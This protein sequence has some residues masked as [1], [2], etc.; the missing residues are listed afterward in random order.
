MSSLPYTVEI[1]VPVYNEESVLEANIRTLRTYLDRRFP[2]RTLIT[3]ADNAS[4]DRTWEIAAR[5][6][7]A[8]DGVRSIHLAEK[9][10]GRALKAVWQS[11]T[12]QVVA[13]MDVDLSTGL[14]AMLPLVAPL[15]SGH[16]DVAIGSRLASGARVIRGPKREAISRIYNL[17]IRAGTGNS[18]TDAQCGFK[19]VRAATAR[20]LLPLVKDNGWFFDTELLMLAEHNGLRIHEVPVDW[21][22]DP[23][24]R[25]DIVSTAIGDL[26]GLWRVSRQFA[27]GGG[28]TAL[29]CRRPS[30][31]RGA[32]TGRFL[33]IGG[34]STLSYLALFVGLTPGVGRLEANALAL[35]LC[36]VA[37]VAAHRRYTFTPGNYAP[38]MDAERSPLDRG[39]VAIMTAGISLGAGLLLTTAAITLTGLVS[40]SLL[41]ALAA[42]TVANALV[43]AGRFLTWTG[44]VFRHHLDQLAIS[45]ETITAPLAHSEP[46]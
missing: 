3:I 19:A 39:A 34:I 46:S 20:Q 42:V 26:K 45:S 2:L 37:N 1:V 43:S 41:V 18:F 35:T 27:A 29:S 17:I 28:R 23:D 30:L 33:G 14:D 13:Y 15:I 4:T 21:V 22:D 24:S 16:S 36:T 8:L 31:A 38:G 32:S 10:R 44:I 7:A 40:R 11:S 9:G 5:L 12:A 25:V 6:A